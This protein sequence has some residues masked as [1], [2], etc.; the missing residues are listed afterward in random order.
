[1]TEEVNAPQNPGIFGA[2]DVIGA[3]MYVYTAAYE[4]AGYAAVR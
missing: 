4:G 1:M 2:G 3:P